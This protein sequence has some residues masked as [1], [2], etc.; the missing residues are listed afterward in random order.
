MARY[1]DVTAEE[2]FVARGGCGSALYEDMVSPLLHVLPMGP[3]YDISAAAALSCFHVFALQSRGAF[4]VRWGRGGLTPSI[5]L[6]WQTQLEARGNVE[7]RSGA[8]VAGISEGNDG[9]P[10]SVA[11]V[12]QEDAPIDADAVVLAVGATSAARLAEA[13][14]ALRDLPSCARWSELRGITCVAVWLFLE[15]A[16]RATTGLGG[17][18]RPAAAAAVAQAMA[19]SPVAV[20]TR[21]CSPSSRTGFYIYDLGARRVRVRASPSRPRLLPCRSDRRDRGR[22]RGGF[23]HL[24]AAAPPQLPAS[25]LDASAVVDSPSSAR[26]AVATSPRGQPR[27]PPVRL[28]GNDVPS[29]GGSTARVASWSTEKAVVTGREAEGDRAR[30]GPHRRRLRRHRRPRTPQLGARRR[31]AVHAAAPADLGLPPRHGPRTL[32]PA[33]RHQRAAA[34]SGSRGRPCQPGDDE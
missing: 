10:L 11:V 7:L 4:D 15:P 20:V 1:D 6:P 27:S 2:L 22:R 18:A 30:P 28:G 17:G 25:A 13:S 5:F 8:R 29:G 34:A 21:A 31:E 12:G 32:A 26:G 3:G 23:A 16:A 33:R 19:A 14:P 9:S 24:R